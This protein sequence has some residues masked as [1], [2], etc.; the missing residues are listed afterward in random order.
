MPNDF[1]KNLSK[2]AGKLGEGIK[3]GA[4]TIG[5]KGSEG[6]KT[7]SQKGSEVVRVN[8]LKF[9]MNKLEKEMDNNMM[10]L[11]KLVYLQFKNEDVSQDEIERL[12]ASAK[13]LEDDMAALELE[14]SS[15][16]PLCPGCQTEL[17]EGV[18]FCPNCGAKISGDN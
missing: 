9:E 15:K 18:A 17:P 13:S 1:L 2:G 6:A 5:Q 14:I 8:K 4:K 12:L 10:A 11:G 3:E 16:S 7:I